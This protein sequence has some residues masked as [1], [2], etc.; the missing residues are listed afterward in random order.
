VLINS[1][2]GDFGQLI[3]DSH[4]GVVTF[5]DSDEEVSKYASEIITLLGDA[6]TAIRCRALSEKSLSL[7]LGVKELLS[8]Y[9]R[10]EFA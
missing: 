9:K 10:V 8:I 5:G 6:E 4:A 2:Q 3:G 1:Q 7:D